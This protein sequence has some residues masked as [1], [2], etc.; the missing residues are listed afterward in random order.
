MYAQQYEQASDMREQPILHAPGQS[1]QQHV[2]VSDLPH[3]EAHYDEDM[4]RKDEAIT[5]DL[6]VKVQMQ[7]EDENIKALMAQQNAARHQEQ[8]RQFHQ[9]H[10]LARQ[11][12]GH[13]RQGYSVDDPHYGPFQHQ[14]EVGPS[15]PSSLPTSSITAPQLGEGRPHHHPQVL[16]SDPQVPGIMQ[17]GELAVPHHMHGPQHPGGVDPYQKQLEKIH[18]Q[19]RMEEQ[20][21]LQAQEQM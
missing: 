18:Y 17:Y 5:K 14:G 15:G 11:Q 3:H 9:E 19:R 6:A 21:R 10:E 8:D 20:Q 16:P 13:I 12:H 2:R 7:H 4:R 1:P